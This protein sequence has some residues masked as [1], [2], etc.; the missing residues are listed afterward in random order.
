MTVLAEE[1]VDI[2]TID[3]ALE[4]RFSQSSGCYSDTYCYCD[5]AVLNHR[6]GT[7]RSKDKDYMALP[8]ELNW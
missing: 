5:V 2:D 8:E 3:A 4:K 1:L 7:Y 6:R